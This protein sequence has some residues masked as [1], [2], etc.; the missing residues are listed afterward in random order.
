MSKKVF[1]TIA[2]ISCFLLLLFLL[3]SISLE[4]ED[5]LGKIHFNSGSIGSIMT[6][7]SD[8][9]LIK[10]RNTGREYLAI[11]N[12]GDEP[13]YLWLK[14]YTSTTTATAEINRV[15]GIYLGANGG[16]Y[17]TF[18]SEFLWSGDVWASST[19]NPIML[20]YLEK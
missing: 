10:E 20:T 11:T 3:L 2:S 9:T 6:D 13:V 19:T 4:K 16:S 18:D 1:I 8:A 12:A 14:N 7:T 17:E 15:G 5:N